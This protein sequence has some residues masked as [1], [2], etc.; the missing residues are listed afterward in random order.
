MTNQEYFEKLH[1][2]YELALMNYWIAAHR[3]FEE[4]NGFIDKKFFQDLTEASEKL[5]FSKNQHDKF[6]SIVKTGKI[7]PNGQF[8]LDRD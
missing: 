8:K 1:F 2:E 7:D 5:D 6:I 4:G 3:I